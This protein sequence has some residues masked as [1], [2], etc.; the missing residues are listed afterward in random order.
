[1]EV[2]SRGGETDV[3][4]SLG[5]LGMSGTEGGESDNTSDQFIQMCLTVDLGPG[6]RPTRA[7]IDDAK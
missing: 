3:G 2:V 6:D 5:S 7:W 1:M 4:N